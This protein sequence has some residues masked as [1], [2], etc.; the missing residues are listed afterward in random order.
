M[1][2]VQMAP[3]AYVR[4]SLANEEGIQNVSRSDFRSF[5]AACRPVA[6]VESRNDYTSRVAVAFRSV[7]NPNVHLRALHK[8]ELMT[9]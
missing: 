7:Q 1:F 5:E 4:V 8:F 3:Q 2:R 9:H 6:L